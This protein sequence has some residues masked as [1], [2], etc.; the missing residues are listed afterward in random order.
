MDLTGPDRGPHTLKGWLPWVA[1]A[2]V[3][4]VLAGVA[5]TTLFLRDSRTAEDAASVEDV[6]DLAVE[7]A[8]DLDVDAGMELLCEAPMALYRMTLMTIIDDARDAAGTVDPDVDYKV[9]DVSDGAT[10]SFVVEVTS[11]EKG[12]EDRELTSRVFVEQ[13]GERSCVAGIGDPDAT[14][15]EITLSGDGYTGATPPS[16]P[17]R[18]P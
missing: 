18:T 7:A 5:V 15:P 12:L 16:L 6:A 8:Q 11:S 4:A 14:E 2:I 13:R 10:G 17:P 1:A 3:M 9:S